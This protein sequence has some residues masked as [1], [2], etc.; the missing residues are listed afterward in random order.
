VL[1]IRG[2]YSDLLT[3]E[4]VVQMQVRH[5]RLKALTVAGQGHAPSLTGDA[6][7]AIRNLIA[8]AETGADVL[9]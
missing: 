2:E 9:I 5:P 6:I 7:V 8:E 3:A 1:V 4:T